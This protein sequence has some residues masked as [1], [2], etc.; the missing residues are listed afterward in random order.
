MP[1]LQI[2]LGSV[3]I[4][5]GAEHHVRPEGN[6]GN[7]GGATSPFQTIPQAARVARAGDVV[8]VGPGIYRES[9]RL[10]H[11][12]TA[13]APIRFEGCPWRAG[14][15]LGNGCYYRLETSRRL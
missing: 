8:I 2:L 12:G 5:I 9:V 4:M 13:A 11:N 10:K 7:S 6:D 3:P 14:C 15:R 1:T